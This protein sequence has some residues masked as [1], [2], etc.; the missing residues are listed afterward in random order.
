MKGSFNLI[1]FKFCCWRFRLLLLSLP[2]K[3]ICSTEVWR[4]TGQIVKVAGSKQFRGKQLRGDQTEHWIFPAPTRC[5]NIFARNLMRRPYCL[6]PVTRTTS[7]YDVSTC[8][9]YTIQNVKVTVEYNNH[10]V[11]QNWHSVLYISKSKHMW[12]GKYKAV[13]LK[14]V[15]LNGKRI[16]TQIKWAEHQISITNHFYTDLNIVFPSWQSIITQFPWYE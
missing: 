1:C 7:E 11:K 15:G 13:T 3:Y 14:R 10:K 2:V 4:H 12:L 16:T 8:V 5:L 9:L 6:E